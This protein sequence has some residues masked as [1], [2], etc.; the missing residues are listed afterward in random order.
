MEIEGQ[1][2]QHFPLSHRLG[3]S[4]E[5]DAVFNNNQARHN[6]P[7]LLILAKKNNHAFNRL[8][9]VVSKKSIQGSVQRNQIKRHIRETFRKIPLR[10]PDG[11]DI[12]VMTRPKIKEQNNITDFLNSA[13]HSLIAKLR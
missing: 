7:E 5:F 4:F 8:G 2:D 10:Q 12:V 3:H 9:M 1:P 6:S 11:W 13:F